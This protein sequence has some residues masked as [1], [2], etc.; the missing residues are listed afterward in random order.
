LAVHSRLVSE[1]SGAVALA[2]YRHVA[3][4]GPTAVVLSGGNIETALLREILAGASG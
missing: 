4:A 2:G 3:P 1:P